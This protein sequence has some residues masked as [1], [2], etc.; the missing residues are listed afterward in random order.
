MLFVP[1]DPV[2]FVKKIKIIAGIEKDAQKKNGIPGLI[3]ARLLPRG[4][5]MTDPICDK[6]NTIPIAVPE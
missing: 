2:S 3:L 5:K 6:V 1:L 4:G